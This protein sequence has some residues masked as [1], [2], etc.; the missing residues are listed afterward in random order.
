[1]RCALVICV[2]VLLA[3]LGASTSGFG[4]SFLDNYLNNIKLDQQSPWRTKDNK[5]EHLTAGHRF[6]Q[7]FVTGPEVREIYQIAV[8]SPHYNSEWTEGTSLVLSLYDSPERK[9]KLSSFAMKYEWRS[10][11]DMVIV[12]PV[13]ARVSPNREYYFELTAEGGAGVIGPILVASGDY[14]RG[15]AY[16]D[17][18]ARDFDF[19]FQTYVHTTWDRNATYRQA[20]SAFDLDYPGLEKVKSAVNKGDWDTAAKELVKHFENRPSFKT[21]ANQPKGRTIPDLSLAELAADMKIK[22]SDG[23]ILEL[24]P[25]W[26]HLKWWPTRGGVGLTRE[27][28]RKYLAA[29]YWNTKDAKYAIAWNNMLK[30]MLTDLP[31]PI[32]AG[33]IAPDAKDIPPI[34]PGGIAGG[35]M[36]SGLAIGARLAHEFYYYVL[37]H[38]SP[39]FTWDVRAAFI[40]NLADMADV[41]AIQKGGGN[42]A[43]QMFD[44][45][46]YFS[47]E[48]PEFAKSKQYGQYAFDGMIANMRE[49]LLPDGPIGESAGYQMLVHNQYMEVIDRARNLG[50]QVPGDVVSNIENA[51]AFHMYTIQPDGKR[52]P[53]GDAL[54]DD[55]RELLKRGAREFNR[56]DML[57]VATDGKEGEPPAATSI[58]YPYSKYYVMRSDWTPDARYLCL[59]N[60]RYT[61]HGHFDSLGFV[62]Y[63]YGNPLLVDPGIFI[64]GTPDAV[65][66]IST[67]SHNTI[68]VDGANLHNGGSPNQF[69]PARGIDYINAIGPQYQGLDESIYPV[70]RIA[71]LKPDYWVM[72]DIVRGSGEHEI[73]SRFHFVDKNAQLDAA[74]QVARTTHP[75]GGNLA[76]IPL[77]P[78]VIS[79]RM[80]DADTAYVH[81]KLEP[82]LILRQH[83]KANLPFRMDNLLYPYIDSADV[84]KVERMVPDQA[85]DVEITGMK[86]ETGRGVDYVAF[87]GGADVPAVFPDASLSFSAQCAVVRRDNSGKIRSFS[88]IWGTRLSQ[89]VELARSTTALPGLDVVYDND[90]VRITTKGSEPSLVISAMG[91][92]RFSVND[93]QPMPI[94]SENGLFRPFDSE[95]AEECLVVDDETAAFAIEKPIKGSSVGGEDQFGFSYY[96]AHVAPGREGLISYTPVLSS[97]GMYEV[98]AYVPKFKLVETTREARYVVFFDPEGEWVSP[99]GSHIKSIDKTKADSGEITL[100]VDQAGAAGTWLSLGTYSFAKGKARVELRADAETAGPVMLAD[101]LKWTKRPPA[102]Q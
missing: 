18:D 36:W 74:T 96:W 4:A 47:T 3:V 61:S 14:P 5:S 62:L 12:F 52:P 81:E 44:H 58:E 43:T 69:F 48:F 80:E 29:G 55:P 72:S 63:G 98:A 39:D 91:R 19:A 78:S 100:I 68:S 99:S 42:W 54:G 49:T 94:K 41:L 87:T 26:N 92:T 27:G 16:I 59:K 11:E 32:K 37:F 25:N 30:A 6:G 51:L 28:I 71:F 22:D 10:W 20:F 31:S 33:V 86:I 23:N 2:F 53:F 95:I 102:K 17:D 90:I 46:F 56:Q 21:I 7:T 40:F 38:D 97:G 60:G 13:K 24:G 89:G 101:A 57:W 8:Q 9:R 15:S 82:A 66:L 85:S 50:L 77:Q 79:S 67:A 93:G 88:W 45:L 73:D 83:A 64:Y 1:M 65:R 76:V 34:N 35:S 84:P 75:T 70:R